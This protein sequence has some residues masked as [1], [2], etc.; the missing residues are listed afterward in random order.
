MLTYAQLKEAEA[1]ALHVSRAQGFVPM[2]IVRNDQPRWW[3]WAKKPW[4]VEL[5]TDSLDKSTIIV[6]EIMAAR[7]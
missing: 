5:H 1:L 3:D 7:E 6:G 2:A 4:R